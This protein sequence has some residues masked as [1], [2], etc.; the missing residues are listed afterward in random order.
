M[1]EL[2]AKKLFPETIIHKIFEINFSFHVKYPPMGKV[3]YLFFRSSWLVLKK[4]SFW[5]DDWK[6]VYNSSKF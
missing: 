2:E 3:Q 6:P 1:G 4:F 5:H